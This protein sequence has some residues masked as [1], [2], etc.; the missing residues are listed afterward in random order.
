MPLALLL[1][2]CKLTDRFTEA[3]VSAAVAAAVEIIPPKILP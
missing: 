2:I 3:V 1:L